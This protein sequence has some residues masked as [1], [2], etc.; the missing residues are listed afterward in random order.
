[1]CRTLDGL[2][3]LVCC[4][5][6]A[7]PVRSRVDATTSFENRARAAE[8]SVHVMDGSSSKS[9]GPC[10]L[11]SVPDLVKLVLQSSSASLSC[12]GSSS[13]PQGRFFPPWKTPK[14]VLLLVVQQA[15]R[16]ASVFPAASFLKAP[17]P[18]S[19]NSGTEGFMRPAFSTSACP[20]DALNFSSCNITLRSSSFLMLAVAYLGLP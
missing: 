14:L 5:C 18:S 10:L 3:K 1:M 11:R 12:P 13:F 9:F 19:T 7:G 2:P 17:P 6:Q 15:H 4:R 16:M 20:W 8:N